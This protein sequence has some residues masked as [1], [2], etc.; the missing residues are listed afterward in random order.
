MATAST[1]MGI[2]AR[3]REWRARRGLSQLELA[4]DAGISARHLSFVE[5]GRSKPGR[6]LLLRI[7][8]QLGLP[9]RESNELLLAA[10]HAP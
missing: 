1:P 6:D 7:T 2:G 10:G 4:L 5:T 8:E 9:F 3:L